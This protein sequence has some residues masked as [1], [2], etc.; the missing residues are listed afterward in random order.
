[1]DEFDLSGLEGSDI[2]GYGSVTPDMQPDSA[3][4]GF[5]LRNIFGDDYVKTLLD[6]IAR[7]IPGTAGAV[8]A[9]QQTNS[10][11]SLADEYLALGAPSRARY[12]SSFTPGF[13]MSSDPGFTDALNQSAKATLH[14]LS[15]TGNPA[16]NPNAWMQTLSDVNSKL[17]YPALQDYRRTNA[18]TG[19]IASLTGAAPNDSLAAINARGNVY[20]AA[21]AA[22]AD[23]FTPR[24]K[25]DPQDL[26]TLLQL[27]GLLQLTGTNSGG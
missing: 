6:A 18:E 13:S 15:V 1:M 16:D 12:E 23:V 26:K 22:A 27:A 19:G 2:P 5:R 4:L 3:S 17:A 10:L 24:P 8:A 7:G 14:G 9:K 21:G 25:I 20:N 11:K